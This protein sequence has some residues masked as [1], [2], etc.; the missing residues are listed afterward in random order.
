LLTVKTRDEDNVR[1]KESLAL[2]WATFCNWIK[3]SE[4][5]RQYE[6]TGHMFIT[7]L[8]TVTKHEVQCEI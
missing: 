3:I 1:Y 2:S 7:L 5:A 6:L 8:Y 4:R